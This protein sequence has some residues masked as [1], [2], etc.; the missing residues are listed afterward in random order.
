MDQILPIH[1]SS[2]GITGCNTFGVNYLLTAFKEIYDEGKGIFL[3]N[4][5]HLHKPVTK[6]NWQTET[7]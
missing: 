1:G 7:R 5:G 3:A 4:I 2:A 6:A